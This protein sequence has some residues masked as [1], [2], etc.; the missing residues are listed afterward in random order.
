MSGPE[1][2]S[3][4][5]EASDGASVETLRRGHAL[6]TEE[7]VLTD[8][9]E[10]FEEWVA[11]QKLPPRLPGINWMLDWHRLLEHGGLTHLGGGQFEDGGV[12]YRAWI[13]RIGAHRLVCLERVQPGSPRG[14]RHVFLRTVTHDLRG[15]LANVRSYASLLQSPRFEHDDRTRKGLEVII[16]NTDRTLHLI[17]GVFDTFRAEIGALALDPEPTALAPLFLESV[18]H[19]RAHAT[20]VQVTIEATV[21]SE[22][23]Q[24]MMDA[25]RMRQVLKAFWDVTVMQASAGQKI[26]GRLAVVGRELVCTLSHPGPVPSGDAFSTAFNPVRAVVHARKLDERFFL[27]VAASLLRVQG[28]EPFL[29]TG[30]DGGTLIGFCLPI[31]GGGGRPYQEPAGTR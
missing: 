15:P 4:R 3:E 9:D 31:E 13:S 5:L 6:F 16:R 1:T 10:V 27:A 21:E 25:D 7:G 19:A 12:Q 20:L 23:P 2:T 14:L 30:S 28:G 29:R 8:A 24:V 26:S 18:E 11:V 22:L 17:N